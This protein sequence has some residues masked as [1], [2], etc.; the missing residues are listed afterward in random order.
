[1]ARGGSPWDLAGTGVVKEDE[2]LAVTLMSPFVRIVR[3]GGGGEYT[4]QECCQ[5]GMDEAWGFALPLE[6]QVLSNTPKV[7][8]APCPGWRD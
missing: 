7:Q 8:R 1:M 3:V 6:C 5:E 2:S 4:P